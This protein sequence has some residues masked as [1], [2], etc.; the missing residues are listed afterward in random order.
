MSLMLCDRVTHVNAE[1]RRA[2]PKAPEPTKGGLRFPLRDFLLLEGLKDR[3]ESQEQPDAH[4]D[5]G[6]GKGF[7]YIVVS[8][9]P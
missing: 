5:Q 7:S 1:T 9:L 8:I 6:D 2:S 3:R 4:Q